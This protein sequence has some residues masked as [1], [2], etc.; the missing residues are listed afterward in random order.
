[1]INRYGVK[2]KMKNIW[3]IINTPES[4]N[5]IKLNKKTFGLLNHNYLEKILI[6]IIHSTSFKIAIFK[7]N[8]TKAKILLSIGALNF[9]DL[10]MKVLAP[11]LTNAFKKFL[12]KNTALNQLVKNQYYSDFQN[13]LHKLRYKFIARSKNNSFCGLFVHDNK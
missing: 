12:P 1:M 2:S 7:L 5:A 4:K 13:A 3:S 8:C 11:N 9:G 10:M 6:A